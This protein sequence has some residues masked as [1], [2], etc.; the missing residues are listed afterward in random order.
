MPA[1][2]VQITFPEGFTPG[3]ELNW[4]KPKPG[5]PSHWSSRLA[6]CIHCTG[7]TNLRTASGKP[8]HKVCAEINELNLKTRMQAG[9]DPG[10]TGRR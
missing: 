10:R 7:P 3:Y 1:D 8:S 2:T 5:G 6:Q 4:G 9:R